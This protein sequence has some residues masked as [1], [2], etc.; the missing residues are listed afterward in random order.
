MC[1]RRYPGNFQANLKSMF[2]GGA[3]D[4][5]PPKNRKRPTKGNKK[6]SYKPNGS[7]GKDPTKYV[8]YERNTFF[9]EIVEV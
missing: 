7:G 9:Y 5:K 3:V 2:G 6:P 1:S 4:T 8:L